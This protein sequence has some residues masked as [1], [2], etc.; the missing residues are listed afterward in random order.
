MTHFHNSLWECVVTGMCIKSYRETC[1]N[2]ETLPVTFC[3]WL[4]LEL[5]DV[6]R[7]RPKRFGSQ[8]IFGSA[9]ACLQNCKDIS[10]IGSHFLETHWEIHIRHI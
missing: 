4:G 6:L 1:Q 5:L 9:A 3:L 2:F 7:N 10:L 8:G